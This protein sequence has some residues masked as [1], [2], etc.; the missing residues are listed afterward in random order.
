MTPYAYNLTLALIWAALTADFSAANLAVGALVGFALLSVVLRADPR[1]TAYR[2]RLPRLLSF[3][4][5]FL[6]E[7]VRSNLRV[8]YDVITPT[9]LMRPAIIALPLEARTELEIAALANLISLTPGTL[10]LQLNDSNTELYVHVMY[11]DDETETLA[12]LKDLER[13]ILELLR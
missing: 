3:A 8:A 6:R 5:Y 12:G 7:L 11:L 1:F 9:H 10:S 2:R 13:R 4:L